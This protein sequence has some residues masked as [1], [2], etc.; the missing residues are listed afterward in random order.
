M[1]KYEKIIL[2]DYVIFRIMM[3]YRETFTFRYPNFKLQSTFTYINNQGN[4]SIIGW[5]GD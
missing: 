3:K 4:I 2:K 5:K 1:N